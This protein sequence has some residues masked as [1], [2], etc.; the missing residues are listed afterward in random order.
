MTIAEERT[1]LAGGPQHGLKADAYRS[2]DIW[3]KEC[4]TVLSKNW[5]FIGFAHQVASPGDAHPITCAG[6]PL[7]TVRGQ[8]GA[9]QVFH[10]VCLHRCMTLVDKPKNVGKLIRC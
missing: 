3:Q 6:L 7:L 9:I 10:N 4:R 1:R 2:E 5:V 8:D